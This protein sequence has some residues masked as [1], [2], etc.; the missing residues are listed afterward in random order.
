MI[1]YLIFEEGDWED[2][3]YLLKEIAETPEKAIKAL[4]KC[5]SLTQDAYVQVWDTAKGTYIGNLDVET[6]KIR[7]ETDSN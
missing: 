4:K 2:A 1:I 3:P 7:K 5:R 6:K